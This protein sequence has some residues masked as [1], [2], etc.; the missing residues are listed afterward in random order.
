VAEYFNLIQRLPPRW[1][2]KRRTL[3][4]SVRELAAREWPEC[5]AE[6]TFEDTYRAALSP[7]L[8]WAIRTYA[9][10][11]FPSDLSTL[12]AGYGGN[13]KGGIKKQRAMRPDEL[14][15]LFNGPECAAFAANPAQHGR[16]WLPLV[17]LYTG[18]RVNEVCQ[19]NPQCDIR[20]DPASGI[21]FFD[22]TDESETAEDVT[23]SVKNSA[24]KRPVPIHS[25]LIELGLLDY[26]ERIKAQGA[27][28]FFPEFSPSKGRASGEAEKWF[29]RHL[30]KLGLR[31]DTEGARLV[32]FHTFRHTFITQSEYAREPRYGLITGHA[33]IER[34][35]VNPVG[36]GYKTEAALFGLRMETKRDVIE[37]WSF[38]I[39][40]PKPSCP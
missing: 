5:M 17:G 35:P 39:A 34:T 22:L 16:Y 27:L 14:S 20:Q 29:R 31:D 40:P 1:A 18:A 26:V 9:R 32:G 11:G 15:T 3:K 19:L 2:D 23:K 8:S 4:L 28:L 30:E 24:S 7:F 33:G 6:K 21:W 13:R 37:K 25:K 12:D 36:E 38:D 10:Q